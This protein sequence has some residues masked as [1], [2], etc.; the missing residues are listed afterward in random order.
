VQHDRQDDRETTLIVLRLVANGKRAVDTATLAG[1]D[2]ATVRR[3]ACDYGY[4]DIGRIRESIER[5]Q[6]QPNPVGPVPVQAAP[7]IVEH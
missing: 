4:P 2:L 1:V 3:T 6:N 7:A 5:L